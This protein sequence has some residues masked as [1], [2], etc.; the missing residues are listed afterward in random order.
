MDAYIFA[1]TRL[2]ELKRQQGELLLQYTADYPLV[3]NVRD[4]IE[5]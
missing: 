1:T 2:E 5:T 3:R 4:R